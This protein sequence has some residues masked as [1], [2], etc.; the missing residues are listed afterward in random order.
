MSGFIAVIHTDGTPVDRQLLG[1]L[2]DSLYFRGPDRQQVWIDGSTGLGHTLFRTT[3]EARHEDQPASLDGKTWITGCIR[4]D[5]REDLLNQLGMQ[6]EI[7]L[8]DT[9]DSHLV[10]HAYRVWGEACLGHLLGDFSFALWDSRQKKLFCARDRFGMRQL[11]YARLGKTFIVSNSIY[12]IRQH[13]GVS[14]RLSDTAIGDPPGAG[15]G[16][17]ILGSRAH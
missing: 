17:R 12:S 9:P 7:K 8:T 14:D 4:I 15:S 2:T 3:H 5:A 11:C 6:H 10:L 1:E 16:S 13:P